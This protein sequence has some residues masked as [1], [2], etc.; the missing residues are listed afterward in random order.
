MSI[1]L[2]FIIGAMKKQPKF[3]I[4]PGTDYVKQRKALEDPKMQLPTPKGVTFEKELLGGVETER[5]TPPNILNDNIIFYIHGGGFVYGNAFTSRGYGSVLADECGMITY[6]ISYRCAPEH[7]FPAGVDDCFSVYCELLKKY[8]GK[9]IALVGESAGGNLVL[10]TALRAKDEGVQMPACI[11]SQSPSTH[12]DENLPSA[13]KNKDVDLVVPY[14][15]LSEILSTE[16]LEEG[17][18]PKHPYVSPYYGDYTDF[19]PLKLTV[20]DSEVLFDDSDYLVKKVKEAG[21]DVDY[22]IMTG[23]FHTFPAIGRACP[24]S[25]KILEETAQFIHKWC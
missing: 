14:E 11:F 2:K 17:T 18:D 15:N 13:K 12:M 16:Y 8:P 21:V 3:A 1:A 7:K 10:V 6:T 22:Q 20:D 9:K 19:P 25:K 4:G 24:E 23:T 5:I